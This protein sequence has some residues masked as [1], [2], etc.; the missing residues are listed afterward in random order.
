MK[1]HLVYEII[2][3]KNNK[4][5]VGL[6]STNII[7]D[8]YMGSSEILLSDMWKIGLSNFDKKILGI[9]PNRKLAAAFEMY[10]ISGEYVSPDDYNVNGNITFDCKHKKMI[11]NSQY[12]ISATFVSRQTGVESWVVRDWLKR[13]R[14]LTFRSGEHLINHMIACN[15]LSEHESGYTVNHISNTTEVNTAIKKDKTFFV[16]DKYKKKIWGNQGEAV[17]ACNIVK[18][19]RN[20]YY[21]E[22]TC[23]AI[24]AIEISDRAGLKNNPIW[25]KVTNRGT[26]RKNIKPKE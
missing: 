6:H 21:P 14:Y 1:Y 9:F 13:Y 10:I 17:K 19:A 4:K 11:N 22:S 5:Y 3:R 20:E 18:N 8:G 25:N 16:R 2:N 15:R 24:L 26:Y 23:K 7:D 12:K